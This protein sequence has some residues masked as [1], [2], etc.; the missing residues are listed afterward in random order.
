MTIQT[1]E[2]RTTRRVLHAILAVSLSAAVGCQS[3]PPA[4]VPQGLA[5]SQNPG[6]S[7]GR[8]TRGTTGGLGPSAP[9]GFRAPSSTDTTNLALRPGDV[10]SGVHNGS[11][12]A[13]LV[14]LPPGLPRGGRSDFEAEVDRHMLALLNQVRRQNGAGPLQFDPRL[15]KAAWFHA[16][17]MFKRG[18]ID[19]QTRGSGEWP[20]RRAQ[21]A[22][23]PGASTDTVNENVADLFQRNDPAELARTAIEMY[24]QSDGHWKNL[25]DPK[26]NVVGLAT[27]FR[28]DKAQRDEYGEPMSPNCQLFGRL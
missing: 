3:L 6:Y 22:G 15:Q 1:T 13:S 18:Y 28:P 7:F 9:S 23:F 16:Y 24:R 2:A 27:V 11:G 14:S 4:G 20:W 17:D 19:H 5:R 26:W 25:L 12:P 8:T 10:T 21:I